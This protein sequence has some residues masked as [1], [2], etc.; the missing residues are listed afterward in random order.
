M[1]SINFTT[2]E[3]SIIEPCAMSLDFPL[4]VQSRKKRI[5][6]T[7]EGKGLCFCCALLPRSREGNSRLHSTW[8]NYSSFY[9]I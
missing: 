7:Q 4:S 6:L 3:T 8:F 1:Q 9:C 5:S 2:V